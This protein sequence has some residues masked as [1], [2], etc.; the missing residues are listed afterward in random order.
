MNNS[1]TE[2][3]ISDWKTVDERTISPYVVVPNVFSKS[4]CK[5]IIASLDKYERTPAVTWHGDQYSVNPQWRSL[6]TANITRSENVRWIYER[7]DK[8]FFWAAE[9]WDLDVRSTLEDLKYL[10]YNAGSHFSQWHRDSGYKHTALRKISMSIELCDNC[11]YEGGELH[12]FP[13]CREHVAGPERKPGHAVV[14]PSHHYHRVTEVT[15]GTRYA[16]VNWIC[17]PALR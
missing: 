1:N 3:S 7:M 16:L 9:L 12:V 14:F 2:V 13:D 4:E 11:E 15:K 10:V 17:G 8:V 6:E 5:S